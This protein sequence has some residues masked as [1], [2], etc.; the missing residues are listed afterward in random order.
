MK[1]LKSNP[2]YEKKLVNW[3]GEEPAQEFVDAVDRV[4]TTYEM[5]GR[6]DRARGDQVA[7][8]SCFLALGKLCFPDDEDADMAA[9][10]AEY[11]KECY[12]IGYEGDVA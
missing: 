4:A 1:L 12:M 6:A 3:Y 10:T 11:M 9:A 5:C 8:Q 2:D 7:K